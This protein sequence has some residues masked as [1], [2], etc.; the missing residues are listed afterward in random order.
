MHHL[1]P[2][3][4]TET[5]QQAQTTHRRAATPHKR[6]QADVRKP[7]AGLAITASYR[8]L[9][10]IPCYGSRVSL[11]LPP[12]FPVIWAAELAWFLL[13]RPG[14]ANFSEAQAPSFLGFL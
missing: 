11:L 2:Q 1:Q 10:E 14:F 13:E 9:V 6:T 12:Q 7:A 4:K 3:T 8:Q 5:P